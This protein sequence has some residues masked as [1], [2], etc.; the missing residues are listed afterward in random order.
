VGL[1]SM[2]RLV[3]ENNALVVA[4]ALLCL[5]VVALL[6]LFVWEQR[7]MFN[8]IIRGTN[9]HD[10]DDAANGKPR[11]RRSDRTP[12]EEPSLASLSKQLGDVVGMMQNR[13]CVIDPERYARLMALLERFEQEHQIIKRG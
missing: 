3:A 9:G 8:R 5:V 4:F 6:G 1:S 7:M 2:T 12:V 13:P 11:R 10:R